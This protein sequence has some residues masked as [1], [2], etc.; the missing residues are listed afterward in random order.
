L[1]LAARSVFAFLVLAVLG[2]GQFKPAKPTPPQN[3]PAPPPTVVPSPNDPT[4]SVE[5]RLVRL[6]VSVK[7]QAGAPE[8]SLDRDN[9]RVWDSGIPQTIVAF[10]RNTSV[11]LSIALLID[12]S[13]STNIELH[14]EETSLLRF[15]PT[16]LNAGNASDTFALFSFNWRTTLEVDYSRNLK[17]AERV[18]T[19]LHGEG[20]TSMYDAICLASD[21]LRRREGRHV[22]VIVSDGGDTASYRHFEDAQRALQAADTVIYPIV[23]I[24]I[25]GDAGRNMG[26]EHALQLLATST[27]GRSFYPDSYSHLDEAFNDIL[28][29]LRTQYL[30]GFY[31]R[32]IPERGGMY[33]PVSVRVD[34]PNLRVATRSG[35]FEP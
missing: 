24:P 17:G 13:A 29:E 12:T 7:N 28:T 33:H 2:W 16:L 3:M 32:G 18:L 22:M 5:I 15:I 14:N 4:F 19:R 23:V 8:T 34:K 1:R 20:G 10:E 30:L 26:G 6:L 11:P 31:P 9:F 35:Y 21:T 27:G 25:E